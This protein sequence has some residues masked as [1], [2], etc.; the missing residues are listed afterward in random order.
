MHETG[1]QDL[2][3][4]VRRA[5]KLLINAY[6]EQTNSLSMRETSRQNLDQ[7]VRRALHATKRAHTSACCHKRVGCAQNQGLLHKAINIPR[8][9]RHAHRN[10]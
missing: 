2:D 6:D 4:C 1:R 3:Q 10:L 5:D 7:R 8:L 9:V